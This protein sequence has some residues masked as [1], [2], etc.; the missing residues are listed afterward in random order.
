MI[1]L[2]WLMVLVAAAA[3]IWAVSLATRRYEQSRRAT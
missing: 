1:A 2:G 3:V